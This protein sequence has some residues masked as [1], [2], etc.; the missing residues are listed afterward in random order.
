[1][2]DHEAYQAL[3]AAVVAIGKTILLYLNDEQHEYVVTRMS[4]EFRFWRICK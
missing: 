3:D 1:M 4:D 2:K